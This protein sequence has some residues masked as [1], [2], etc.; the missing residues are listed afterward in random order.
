MKYLGPTA[1]SQDLA[2]KKYVDSKMGQSAADRQ[3]DWY[4]N[5]SPITPSSNGYF[6]YMRNA[7]AKN[8][9]LTAEDFAALPEGY[10]VTILAMNVPPVTISWEN[11]I[12]VMDAVQHTDNSSGGSITLSGIGDMIEVWKH[13]AVDTTIPVGLIISGKLKPRTIHAGTSAPSSGT[14]SDGDVYIQYTS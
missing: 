13:P 11:S 8:F 10:I 5:S 9:T 2:T 3:I 14:G 1:D 7:D 12:Q 4:A 6:I